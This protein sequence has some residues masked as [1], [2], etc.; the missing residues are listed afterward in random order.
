MERTRLASFKCADL[1]MDC[2]FETAGTTEREVMR[3]FIDHAEEAH[4]LPVL[5]ADVIFR[6][7]K[8]IKNSCEVHISRDI[9]NSRASTA[10]TK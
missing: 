6:V 5:P 7:Q 4:N 9:I 2:S 3:T 10:R 1:G 8:S